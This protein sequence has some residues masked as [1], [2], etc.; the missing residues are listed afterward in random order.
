MNCLLELYH[1][2]GKKLIPFSPNNFYFSL[3]CK[4]YNYSLYTLPLACPEN[5]LNI[6][7]V[8]DLHLSPCSLGCCQLHISIIKWA[9]WPHFLFPFQ[10][11][12]SLGFISILNLFFQRD[13]RY[14]QSTKLFPVILK[15]LGGLQFPAFTAF[16]HV[17]NLRCIFRLAFA[18]REL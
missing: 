8:K 2:K 15:P 1:E 5:V 3:L 18:Q 6:L 7:I 10:R 13:K 4:H 11:K 16:F 17:K 9:L 12:T 14:P